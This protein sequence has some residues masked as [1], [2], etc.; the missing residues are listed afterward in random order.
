M[1][2]LASTASADP[3]HAWEKDLHRTCPN[4]NVQLMCDGCYD[5]FLAAFYSTLNQPEQQRMEIVAD[6]SRQCA[7]ELVGFSCEMSRNLYAA[8]RLGLLHKLV[9]FGCRTVK[10]EEGAL[11][12]QF[13]KYKDD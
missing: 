8:Q 4:R 3:W 11:F 13:P 6:T 10:C 1:V 5:E 12:S 2:A 7:K 9:L